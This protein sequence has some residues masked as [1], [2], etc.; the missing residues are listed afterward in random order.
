VRAPGLSAIT[1]SRAGGGVAAVARLIWR[2]FRDEWGDGCRLY[3]L[4]P[5]GALFPP[6]ARTAVRLRFGARVAADQALGRSAWMFH[7]HLA[8]AR[9]QRAIPRVISCPYVVFLHG[10]EV[11]RPLVAAERAVLAGAALLVTN[12]AHTARRLAEVN[13]GVPRPAICPLGSDAVGGVGK[14]DEPSARRS[15]L[16]VARMASSEQYKGHDQLL[17]ALPAVRSRVPDA[18]LVF[19]GTGD[20]VDR[21]KV[22]ARD[23]GVAAAV[24]FTGFLPD[25]ALARA[26]REAAVFAMPSRGEGFGL[27]YLEAMSAAVPCIGS[28]QDAAAEI[29]QDGVT[30][31]LVDQQDTRTLAD[32]LVTLFT[33]PAQRAEMGQ[34]ARARWEQEYTY[35]QFRR[36]LRAVLGAAG[37]LERDGARRIR[38]TIG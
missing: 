13:P 2:V 34:R 17:E 24:T 6:I 7:S 26:Y 10:I 18:R 5:S 22:R 29:I 14:S 27:A 23:L 19:V 15:I 28:R 11:W 37:R 33:D 36:R 31:Y 32:R 25:D 16:T 38:A 30:G 3:E 21:L 1:L 8:V 12:S 9:V 35:Q 20:D 4:S